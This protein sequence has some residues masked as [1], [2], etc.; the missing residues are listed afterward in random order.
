MNGYLT[1]IGRGLLVV[2]KPP[3]YP[4][5]WDNPEQIAEYRYKRNDW[6]H[7]V[8][9]AVLT[10]YLVFLLLCVP[11][12]GWGPNGWNQ[13]AWSKDLDKLNSDRDEMLDKRVGA[14]DSRLAKV[15]NAVATL[16]AE[17]R[18]AQALTI[19]GQIFAVK[20]EQCNAVKEGK[21]PRAWTER[22]KTLEGQYRQIMG[23]RYDTPGCNEV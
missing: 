3:A 6:C 13:V 23:Y 10:C 9:L 18:Q 1:T 14:I 19:E 17:Q 2:L 5:D 16:T 20:K 4:K 21:N 12:F 8:S 22:L 7:A 15:E 11:L